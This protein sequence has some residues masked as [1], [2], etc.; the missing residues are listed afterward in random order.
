MSE[1]GNPEGL[2]PGLVLLS[3]TSVQAALVRRALVERKE[4][5]L[6]RA[7]EGSMKLLAKRYPATSQ[8]KQEV[9]DAIAEIDLIATVLHLLPGSA[10]KIPPRPRRR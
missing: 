10:E 3:L 6:V 1:E 8:E 5:L 7:G 4:G 2:K 9:A